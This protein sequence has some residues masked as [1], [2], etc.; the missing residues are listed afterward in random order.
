MILP[1]Q[2]VAN[3]A[4]KITFIKMASL[5]HYWPGKPYSS[6]LIFHTSQC[7]FSDHVYLTNGHSEEVHKCPHVISPIS[8]VTHNSYSYV[9]I[10]YINT[11]ATNIVC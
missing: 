5:K 10:S 1:I 2:L 4:C 8:Y 7:C 3:I 11:V 6:S 9:V